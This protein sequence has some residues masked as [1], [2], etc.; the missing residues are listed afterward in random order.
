[1][2]LNLHKMLI[3]LSLS[4]ISG[5]GIGGIFPGGWAHF[6]GSWLLLFII[7]VPLFYC[8]RITKSYARFFV[9]WTFGFA[10]QLTA[11][12][13]VDIPA[14]LFGGFSTSGGYTLY[15]GYAF[16]SAFYFLFLMFPLFLLKPNYLKVAHLIAASASIGFLEIVLPRF[17]E[18]TF[19]SLF[20]ANEGMRVWHSL[21]GAS[22]LTV[23]I[24]FSNLMIASCI[25]SSVSV[26]TSRVCMVVVMW[27][28][29]FWG[30]KTYLSYA[31][32][33]LGLAEFIKVAI[34]QP[35]RFDDKSLVQTTKTFVKANPVDLVIWPESAMF[36]NPDMPA[37][38]KLT[39]DLVSLNTPVL[40]QKTVSEHEKL[41]SA[42]LLFDKTEFK[43][44]AFFKW[45]LMPFGEYVPFVG[46]FSTFQN[47]F[48][49]NFVSYTQLSAG[50]AAIVYHINNQVS[51][52]PSIC[53]DGI[54]SKLFRKQSQ[55]SDGPLLF[56]NQA[57]FI[58][59][60]SSN[61]GRQFKEVLRLRAIENG[62][63]LV[64]ASLTGPSAAFD[65]LGRDVAGTSVGETSEI[66]SAQINLGRNKTVYSQFSDI[67]LQILGFFSLLFLL[68]TQRG[69]RYAK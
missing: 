21:F 30:G 34:F 60:G 1:M 20:Y 17:F 39:Q 40:L 66:L 67:P 10:V 49:Q 62:R 6:S 58:W 51:V 47:W 65:A 56:V 50:S 48:R 32:N 33:H 24:V 26:S 53:F 15:I 22:T 3:P 55:M 68:S 4:L 25:A 28:I 14:T 52:A 19:G 35:G 63:P 12:S 31:N 23:L 57:N 38:D 5:I 16:L 44:P 64:L 2:K 36:F 13:W 27:G 9:L 8:L 7:L 42:S 11:F 54:R 37:L 41:F 69:L 61:A 18:W 29:V 43:T 46:G 45:T 59:M